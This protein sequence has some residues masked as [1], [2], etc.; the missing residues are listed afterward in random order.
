[1]IF[2]IFSLEGIKIRRG[3]LLK[4]KLVRNIV[5]PGSPF[6]MRGQSRSS[7][8]TLGNWFRGRNK[9]PGGKRKN[10]INSIDY[11]VIICSLRGSLHPP[12]RVHPWPVDSGKDL[13]LYS[14]MLCENAYME[15]CILGYEP[16]IVFT[17]FYFYLFYFLWIL[18]VN[19]YLSSIKIYFFKRKI[20]NHYQLFSTFID[21]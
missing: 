19:M 16:K 18:L 4:W 17:Y 15:R 11:F 1:M 21:L 12:P 8:G 7:R 6:V 14:I 9:A 20:F 3:S 10:L 5:H 13:I 2:D